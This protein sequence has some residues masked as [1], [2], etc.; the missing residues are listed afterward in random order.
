M[1]KYLPLL[2]GS[3][4]TLSSPSFAAESST[5]LSHHPAGITVLLLFIAAYVCVIYLDCYCDELDRRSAPC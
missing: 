2:L 5:S 4:L 1:S 3:L